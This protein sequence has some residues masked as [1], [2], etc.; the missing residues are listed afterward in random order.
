MPSTTSDVTSIVAKTGRRTHSSDSMAVTPLPALRRATFIP[1]ARLSTSVIATTSPAL[2]AAQDL[3][4]IAEPVAELHFVSD[5][6][7]A[8]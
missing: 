1:S 6:A 4:A 2:D 5:D 7:V 8:V 3:D